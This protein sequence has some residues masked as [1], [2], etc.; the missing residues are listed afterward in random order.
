MLPT[1]IKNPFGNA[2]VLYKE[3][4]ESTMTDARNLRLQ[5]LPS[6]TVIWAG[7][8]VAG[9]GRIAD[10]KWIASPGKNILCTFYLDLQDIKL[11]L[12]AMPLAVGLGIA[13]YLESSWDLQAQI[14][15]PNDIL[16]KDKKIC[17]IL[18]ETKYDALFVGIGLNVNET[19]FPGEIKKKATSIKKE[20]RK[21][22]ELKEVMEDMLNSVKEAIED[23]SWREEIEKRLW[24]KDREISFL[25]GNPTAPSIIRG[26]IIGIGEAGE[27][28]MEDF[29]N[30]LSRLVSGE[31]D[32]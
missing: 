27:L 12:T 18:C 5:K 26:R 16:I 9:R 13:K 20:T 7:H 28:I 1:S 14:K 22:A 30:G 23:N 4:T 8:Q 31:I 24:G 29:D 21:K 25:N 32:F 19:S 10:R 15:W 6:G 11:P 3:E 2:K 17:G